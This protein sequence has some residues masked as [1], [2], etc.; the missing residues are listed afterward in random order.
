MGKAVTEQGS[1]GGDTLTGTSG[2]DIVSAGGSDDTIAGNGGADLVHGGDGN[3]VFVAPDTGFGRFDGR[4]GT[5][6]L[7]FSGASKT[8]DLTAIRGNQINNAEHIDFTGSGDNTLVLDDRIVFA[9]TGDSNTLTGAEHSLVIDGNAGDTVEVHG[10][11]NNTGSV[12][13]GGTG[14]SVYQSDTNHAQ[15]YVNDRVAV[16][17]A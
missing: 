4:N 13:I 14:Y 2:A 11:W 16:T 10:E 5:D 3:D 17:A 15:I 8:F 1:D 9:A 12:T 6:L 7:S